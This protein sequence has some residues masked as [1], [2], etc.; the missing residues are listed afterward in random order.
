MPRL[1][2]A[3]ALPADTGSELHLRVPALDDAQEPAL[4][5]LLRGAS[6]DAAITLTTWLR[7]SMS[8]SA[9][10]RT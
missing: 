6:T 1:A 5:L 2:T 7:Q 10:Q 8:E 9:D 3:A 4:A